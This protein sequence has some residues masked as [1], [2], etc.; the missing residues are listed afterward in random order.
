MRLIGSQRLLERDEPLR[1][2][3]GLLLSFRLKP[4]A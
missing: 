4:A 3:Q 2:A 1:K